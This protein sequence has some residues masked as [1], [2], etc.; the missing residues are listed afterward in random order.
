MIMLNVKKSVSDIYL[1]TLGIGYSISLV[2][3]FLITMPGGIIILISSIL[4]GTCLNVVVILA[5][6][7]ALSAGLFVAYEL[8]VRKLIISDEYFSTP[9]QREIY[10][11]YRKKRVFVYENLKSIQYCYGFER[12]ITR[13]G[14]LKLVSK[15]KLVYNS[16]KVTYADMIR[17]N[18]KQIAFVMAEVQ[19]RASKYNG[20][21]VE[22]LPSDNDKDIFKKAHKK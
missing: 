5:V 19:K 21:D 14:V 9:K 18:K 6:S 10:F 17:F 7:F 1:G 16:G 15:I 3:L 8:L 2:I 4:D 13:F 22:I 11:T 20:Y 12:N